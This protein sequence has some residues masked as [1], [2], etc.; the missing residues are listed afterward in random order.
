MAER[1]KC[2]VGDFYGCKGIE[3]VGD[4]RERAFHSC[5]RNAVGYVA[6][7]ALAPSDDCD[8]SALCR[9]NSC[10]TCANAGACS[11]YDAGSSTQLQVHTR[12]LIVDKK[13]CRPSVSARYLEADIGFARAVKGA[14]AHGS[15]RS[16]A[17]DECRNGCDVDA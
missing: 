4:N 1:G 3:K 2:L 7:K 10:T 15:V 16:E 13:I 14:P 17:N 5:G 8:T 6:E 12:V 11:C 9:E